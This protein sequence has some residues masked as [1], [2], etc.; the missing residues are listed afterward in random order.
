MF[1]ARRLTALTQYC[2]LYGLFCRHYVF[3]MIVKRQYS[4]MVERYQDP[5]LLPRIWHNVVAG[6][7]TLP[8]KLSELE[9]SSICITHFRQSTS[10]TRAFGPGSFPMPLSLVGRLARRAS[11]RVEI[12]G[13]DRVG[14]SSPCRSL[15]SSSSSRSSFRFAILT[16]DGHTVLNTNTRL[17]DIPK[18]SQGQQTD[19]FTDHGEP[20][21]P[22]C[23]NERGYDLHDVV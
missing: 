13:G 19:R 7:R 6:G 10:I 3:S 5:P 1:G 2:S 18:E 12:H 9:K 21:T 17:A 8:V 15:I 4:G 11:V 23:N 16:G 14:K 20:S 22:F